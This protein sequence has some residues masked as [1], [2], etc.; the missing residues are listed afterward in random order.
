M[1]SGLILSSL[2]MK[3]YLFL[4]YPSQETIK[5]YICIK[6][7]LGRGGKMAGKAMDTKPEAQT[8]APRGGR[9]GVQAPV[10]WPLASP[11]IHCKCVPYGICVPLTCTNTNKLSFLVRGWRGP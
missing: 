11:H 4:K 6:K 8:S 3:T 2:V 5:L 1:L 9:R 7:Y 10:G